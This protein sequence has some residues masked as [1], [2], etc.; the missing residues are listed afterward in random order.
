MFVAIAA[1]FIPPCRLPSAA[2]QAA[3]HGMTA[4]AWAS[5]GWRCAR[6][7]RL[8]L[9]I[10]YLLLPLLLCRQLGRTPP[11]QGSS[12]RSRLGFGLD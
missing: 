6:E 1:L 10:L 5:V 8:D 3:L 4:T 2:G 9:L 12:S 11:C 7:Q